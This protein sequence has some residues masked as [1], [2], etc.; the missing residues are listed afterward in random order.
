MSKPLVKVFA[1]TAV[2]SVW[3]TYDSITL[4]HY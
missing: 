3:N 2:S 1:A 4:D